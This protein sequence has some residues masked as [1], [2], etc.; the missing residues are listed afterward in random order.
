[1]K[2]LIYNPP[3][4]C[5]FLRDGEIIKPTD[6]VLT[7]HA[8][9]PHFPLRWYRQD[10]APGGGTVYIGARYCPCFMSLRARRTS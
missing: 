10:N 3:K 6:L 8:N 4:G 1:M 7:N 5:R 9:S 2:T